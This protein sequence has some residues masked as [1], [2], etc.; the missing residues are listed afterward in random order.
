MPKQ[1]KQQPFHEPIGI[2]PE[3]TTTSPIWIVSILLAILILA[4]GVAVWLRLTG[5]I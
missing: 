5:R 4:A 3:E 2:S 1:P